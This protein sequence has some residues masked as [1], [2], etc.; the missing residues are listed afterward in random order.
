MDDGNRVTV[1]IEVSKALADQASEVGIDIAE[2]AERALRDE[3]RRVLDAMPPAER[4]ALREKV[5]QEIQPEIERYNAHVEK[6]G[7]F[8]D[9]WRRF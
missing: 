1:T 3:W 8:S 2:V 4:E 9:R 5:R 6:H 7:L